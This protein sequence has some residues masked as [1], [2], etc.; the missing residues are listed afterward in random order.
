M[1]GLTCCRKGHGSSRFVVEARGDGN[2]AGRARFAVI[3]FGVETDDAARTMLE[4]FLL[5]GGLWYDGAMIY[6]RSKQG[7]I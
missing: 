4:H 3:F 5:A 6:I 7:T 2:C 1:F